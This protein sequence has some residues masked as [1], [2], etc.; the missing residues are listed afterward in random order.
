M[1]LR[2]HFFH[3]Y[4]MLFF[5]PWSNVFFA[6]T[7]SKA[8]KSNRCQPLHSISREVQM[9]RYPG[10]NWDNSMS[11]SMSRIPICC[12]MY[13][14]NQTRMSTQEIKRDIIYGWMNLSPPV[15]YIKTQSKYSQA[16][17]GLSHQ[18][19]K[20]FLSSTILNQYFLYGRW[21]FRIFFI[22]V[23]IL[24]FKDEVLKSI[25]QIAS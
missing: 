3:F 19:F 24:I 4:F 15:H 9:V 10:W 7:S 13:M 8:Q 16:L 25:K 5:S 17:K 20:S 1:C 6:F 18:I 12:C 23:I 11:Y 22:Q 21:W 2:F 14:A